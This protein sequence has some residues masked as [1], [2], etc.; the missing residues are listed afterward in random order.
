M[1]KIDSA[2]GKVGNVLVIS[3]LVGLIIGFV[4]G[5]LFRGLLK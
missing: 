5:I 1:D 3:F 4:L 2:Y